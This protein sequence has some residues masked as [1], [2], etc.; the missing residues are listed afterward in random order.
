L[1]C[2]VIPESTWTLV[3]FRFLWSIRL[4]NSC[5]II[6]WIW[7]I[8]WWIILNC[9]INYTLLFK[10]IHIWIG[11]Y[12]LISIWC[13]KLFIWLYINSLRFTSCSILSNTFCIVNINTTIA[14]ILFVL[15]IRFNINN[16]TLFVTHIENIFIVL[17]LLHLLVIGLIIH[18]LYRRFDRLWI[19]C[20]IILESLRLLLIG[21]IYIIVTSNMRI[22]WIHHRLSSFLI[23][24][25]ERF[26][27]FSFHL[28]NRLEPILVHSFEINYLCDFYILLSNFHLIIL[29]YYLSVKNVALGNKFHWT[30]L[31]LKISLHRW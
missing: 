18:N 1:I 22:H 25:I 11:S 15:R 21:A 12:I 9:S 10:V 26:S 23:L 14:W 4:L 2:V 24:Y 16:D 5:S 31:I 17:F 13:G 20:H 7:I 19:S 3:Q 28:I 8:V 29:I 6:S 27:I 30:H